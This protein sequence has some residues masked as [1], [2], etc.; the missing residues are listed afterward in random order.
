MGFLSN[1]FRKKRTFE[2]KIETSPKN[3]Y[4]LQLLEVQE[5]LFELLKM[6]R[7]IAKSDYYT[8]IC[9]F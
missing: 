6:D 9:G 2:K 7:Y 8:E 1:L 5:F 3:M 4:C